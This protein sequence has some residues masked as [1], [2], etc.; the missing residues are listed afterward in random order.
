MGCTIYIMFYAFNALF[1]FLKK[2][3]FVRDYVSKFDYC[4]PAW[5]VFT[6]LWKFLG[7]ATVISS[8]KCITSYSKLLTR[9]GS[10]LLSVMRMATFNTTQKWSFL[11]RISSLNVTKP[12]FLADLVTFTEEMLNGKLHFLCSEV[13]TKLLRKS[14]NTQ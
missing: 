12:Q 4:I 1:Y 14:Q 7:N 5:I 10:S 2:E 3:S 8:N 9:Y 6:K 13:L 11:L